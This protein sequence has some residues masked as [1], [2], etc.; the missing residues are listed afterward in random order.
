MSARFLPT[1]TTLWLVAATSAAFSVAPVVLAAAAAGNANSPVSANSGH[2]AFQQQCALCHTAQPGDN[3]GAQGPNLFGV[4]GRR[5][6]SDPKFSY[7]QALRDSHLTWDEATLDRFLHAPTQM[8]PGTAMVIA[9]P[10]DAT[11]ASLIAY[12]QAVKAGSYQAKGTRPQFRPTPSAALTKPKDESADWKKDFPGRV[13]H[14]RVAELPA[15]YRTES[16]TN[17]PRLVS[18]PAA[19][20]LRVPKGFH[21][22]VF[23]RELQGPR[24]L[25]VAPNGDIFVSETQLGR[26]VVMRPSAD[27]THPQVTAVFAQGLDLPSGMAFY[28]LDGRPQWIYVAET[29][30]VVRYPYA[31]GDLKARALPQIVVPQLSPVAG[32]GHF[33]RDVVFSPD[34]QRMFVSVGSQSN[35]AEDMPKKSADEV[36]AWAASHALGAAWGNDARRADVL[37]FNVASLTPVDSS[38]AD[39]AQRVIPTVFATGLRNCAALTIQPQTGELWCTVNE[40][41]MLGDNLVPDYST[42][43]QQARFYGWPWYYLGNHEDPRHAGERPDLAGKATVPD[44]LYQS[45]SAPLS[46]AFYTPSSGPSAFPAQYDGDGFAVLHGSWNR[47]FRTGHKIVRVRMHAGVAT[48][49]YDDFLTGFIVNDGNAWGRPVGVVEASDGS[50]ILTDDGANMVYRISYKR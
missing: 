23:S 22:A 19:A 39:A 38:G 27:G 42:H 18:K 10:D 6:A 20:Q 26:I 11:R 28:P 49:E 21:V 41:D 13:H 36:R 47:A 43:V 15:P 16:Y 4:F 48:G 33:T 40:R 1:A 31:V 8:V 44:V 34:G 46:L 29:N 12:F 2:S 35:V 37:M 14:I 50:L 7:T 25:R 30:R 3:G 45:H 32:G 9:V 5:A 24:E 17:F